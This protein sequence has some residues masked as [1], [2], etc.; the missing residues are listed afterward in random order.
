M[1]R[2]PEVPPQATA[3]RLTV[4]LRRADVLGRGDVVDVAV[5]SSRDTLISRVTRL[6]LTYDRQGE[7]GPSRRR[8]LPRVR[9]QGSGLL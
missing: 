4:L 3:D 6:R 5:E 9:T 2:M 1:S 8:D 7:E